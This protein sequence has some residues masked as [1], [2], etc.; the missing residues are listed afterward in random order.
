MQAQ[1]FDPYAR[2]RIPLGYRRSGAPIFPIAGGSGVGPAPADPAFVTDVPPQQPPAVPQPPVGWLS[3]DEVNA[4][5]E[6]ARQEEKDKLYGRLDALG[7]QVTG[8]TE[9]ANEA[10]RLREEAEAAEADRVRREQEAEMTA[11]DLVARTR[12]EFAESLQRVEADWSSKLSEE[13]AAR[14][15]TDAL[16][17]REREFNAL[18]AYKNEQILAHQEEIS[19]EM[20]ADGWITG[21]SKE[22]IDSAIQRAIT[23]TQRIL[24]GIPAPQQAQQIPGEYMVPQ[25]VVGDPSQQQIPAAPNYGARPFAPGTQ[26][27]PYAVGQPLSAQQ[28]KDMSLT[29]YAKNRNVLLG[30]AASSPSDR[31]LLG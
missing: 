11:L 7:T 2:Y 9:Q 4:R 6:K 27:D 15:R 26:V 22:Q 28:I 23:T 31:G 3:P 5:I 17:Q 10:K 13:H 25:Q 14:E 19:P 24:D 29:E 21:D 18:E 20:I 1:P 30:R 16:L 12:T 8:L